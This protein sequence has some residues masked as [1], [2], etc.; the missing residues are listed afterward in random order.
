MAF[1]C[2]PLLVGW[3]ARVRDKWYIRRSCVIEP[4]AWSNWDWE[5]RR[6]SA[7][8]TRCLHTLTHT[9]YQPS[10]HI[11]Y[12][13]P[14]ELEL[15]ER[16]TAKS[17][18]ARWFIYTYTQESR[19]AISVYNICVNICER[20]NSLSLSHSISWLESRT[21]I[22]TRD[23][24][25]GCAR[26]VTVV[27]IEVICAQLLH[28]SLAIGSCYIC[29]GLLCLT[30]WCR[31]PNIYK[32]GLVSLLYFSR[33]NA[34]TEQRVYRRKYIAVLSKSSRC[35]SR[36]VCVCCCLC[37]CNVDLRRENN[38]LI[39][40]LRVPGQCCHVTIKWKCID[41]YVVFVEKVILL[42]CICNQNIIYL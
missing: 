3:N 10:T 35:G 20:R 31:W 39:S 40:A 30:I 22:H 6:Q 37:I 16:R 17:R 38:S 29:D 33:F 34:F 28:E 24:T 25:F 15:R 36:I 9:Q 4:L 27:V 2:L 5:L 18:C 41:K 12:R 32:K 21:F 42:K 8:V 14:R 1:A 11:T 23:D 13:A 19:R 7:K 26:A